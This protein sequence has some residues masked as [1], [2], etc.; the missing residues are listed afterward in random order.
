MDLAK[1]FSE[2]SRTLT[3]H[4]SDVVEMIGETRCQ[5]MEA[6]R[7]KTIPPTSSRMWSPQMLLKKL[8]KLSLVTAELVAQTVVTAVMLVPATLALAAVL[9]R[10]KM[11][12]E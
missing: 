12:R 4:N 7:W 8:M 2:Y 6:R 3:E 11:S 10:K 9:S 1:A 5:A